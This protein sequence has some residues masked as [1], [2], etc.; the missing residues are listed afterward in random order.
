MAGQQVAY[1]AALKRPNHSTVDS[2]P[3]TPRDR[4]VLSMTPSFLPAEL[5]TA[6]Y[7][8]VRENVSD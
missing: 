7:A 2:S 6:S 8:L 4:T 1:P 3:Y 5:P